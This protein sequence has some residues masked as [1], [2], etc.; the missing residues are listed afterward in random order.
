L[1][2]GEESR[3]KKTREKDER[4]LGIQSRRELIRALAIDFVSLL[5]LYSD[6]I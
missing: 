3:E 2:T 5:G 4:A 1:G 6:I